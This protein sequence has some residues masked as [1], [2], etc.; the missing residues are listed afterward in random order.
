MARAK[1]RYIPTD[2]HRRQVEQYASLQFSVNE[3]VLLAG[4][5]DEAAGNEQIQRAFLA[6]R[7]KAQAILRKGLWDRAKEGDNSA[8]K[9]LLDL[10][11]NGGLELVP[12]E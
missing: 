6:G 11:R 4:L 9:Q 2:E 3:V 12:G 8:S 1:T 7:L 5:P 10:S